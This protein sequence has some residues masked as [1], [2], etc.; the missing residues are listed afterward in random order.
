MSAAATASGRTALAIWERRVEAGPSAVARALRSLGVARCCG[1]WCV[2]GV[3]HAQLA[4]E[5]Q[6]ALSERCDADDERQGAIE[7]YYARSADASPRPE[8]ASDRAAL[9]SAPGGC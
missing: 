7:R 4:K 6:A 5:W 1:C 8:A 9:T 3:D 2:S